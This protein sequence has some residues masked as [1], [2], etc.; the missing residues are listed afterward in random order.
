MYINPFV[1]GVIFTIV[2][3]LLLAVVWAIVN[4]NKNNKNN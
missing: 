3:E 2:A 4:G 1:A